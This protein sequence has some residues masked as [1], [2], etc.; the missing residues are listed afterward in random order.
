MVISEFSELLFF[1]G[2]INV[3]DV[4]N[5]Y[6]FDTLQVIREKLLHLSSKHFSTHLYNI[7]YFLDELY[8]SIFLSNIS[9]Y[10]EAEPFINYLRYLSNF[11]LETNGEI[12][13]GYLY[14]TEGIVTPLEGISK[15][16]NKFKNFKDLKS[17]SRRVEVRNIESAEVLGCKDA[18]LV[19]HK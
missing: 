18:V 7:T 10:A 4:N 5:Y 12:Y 19:L 17:F 13:F 8:D 9:Q 15:I 6:D 3:G 2:V 1:S 14:N 16:N 11:Y